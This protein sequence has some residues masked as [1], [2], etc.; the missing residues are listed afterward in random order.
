MELLSSVMLPGKKNFKKIC[1]VF[2]TLAFCSTSVSEL[3]AIR[4]VSGKMGRVPGVGSPAGLRQPVIRLT[5]F[6]S[7]LAAPSLALPSTLLPGVP[8]ATREAI[9]VSP[10]HQALPSI[11]R[12]VLT[13]SAVSPAKRAPV[14]SV[15]RVLGH[16]TEHVGRS[17]ESGNYQKAGASLGT[18]FEA[19][20][21]LP[22]STLTSPPV[23]VLNAADDSFG[24]GLKRSHN[25][26]S[27]ANVIVLTQLQLPGMSI[28]A[29]ITAP[30]TPAIGDILNRALTG[31]NDG[32]VIITSELGISGKAKTGTL[33]TVRMIDDENVLIESVVRVKIGK[34]KKEFS[35]DVHNAAV[36][37]VMEDVPSPYADDQSKQEAYE[38]LIEEIVAGLKIITIT[39]AAARKAVMAI[40]DADPKEAI[41]S[42]FKNVSLP[43]QHKTLEK[44]SK[45]QQLEVLAEA[46]KRT[47]KQLA[48]A[49]K[50]R[51]ETN[52]GDGK[53][54]QSKDPA[55]EMVELIKK[56]GLP[57]LVEKK[58]VEEVEGVINNPTPETQKVLQWAKF[59]LSLPWNQRTE[60]NLD[61]VRAREILDRD[62]FGLDQ[63]KDRIL[64][65][66][67]VRKRLKNKR[68]A[69]L[70]FTGPPGTG[71]TSIAK[72]IAEAMGREYIRISLGGVS[73]ESQLRGH[74]RTFQGSKAGVILEHLRRVNS[75]NPIMVLD[76][77]EKMSGAGSANGDPMAALLEILDPEQ[78]NAFTDHYLDLPFDLSEIIFI[79]TANDLSRIPG[80][81][82]DRLEIIEYHSCTDAEK[83]QI[84]TRYL[85]ARGRGETGLTEDEAV[86]K[87]S[88]LMHLIRSYTSEAGVRNLTRAIEGLFRK[89]VS[90]IETGIPT[91][92][93]ELTPTSIDTLIGPPKV[94]GDGK[95]HNGVGV[96]SALAVSGGGGSVLPIEVH[97]F[98][99]GSGKVEITGNLKETM[100]QSVHVAKTVVRQRGKSLGI[101]DALFKNMDMHIHV[102]QG[103]TP[104]DGPSAG[105]TLVTAI[106][107]R[108]TGRAVKAG[109]AMTGEVYSS[110]E[111]HAIGGLKE[112]VLGAM[113]LGYTTVIYPKENE[114]DV[115]TFSEEVRAGIELIA[116]ETIE[117]VLDLA[118][119]DAA[120]EAP[121]EV[122]K[123]EP[124]VVGAPVND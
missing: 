119:E 108:M 123:A 38:N 36:V 16:T 101:D 32:Y 63:V 110:G 77:L 74:G 59:L 25:Y 41:Y 112:K 53:Q 66:L 105:I 84:G 72:G 1:S 106:A 92:G 60:D 54:Q 9:T 96:A 117:E 12:K 93:L 64:E 7:M 85:D 118:L 104:K 33:A 43:W 70:L 42:V 111:V 11:G 48:E 90:N 56:A 69:I 27:R 40:R 86:L 115:A 107:S 102:P 121:L 79:A 76:E 24:S 113:K 15:L 73:T 52:S 116:V 75:K 82:R 95:V 55:V 39:N 122:A 114:M 58:A 34:V 83:I 94:H 97:A 13:R 30:P 88:G 71:K 28:Q 37:R 19:S 18:F 57:E 78:N 8:L 45:I 21:Q 46:T 44:N 49:G 61:L 26:P 124:A 51:S 35:N 67:A 47:V 14:G 31:V 99:N 68:G 50:K 87:E 80:P 2:I 22:G 81:L 91:Q 23:A 120:A 89:I 20:R 6:S 103:G 10:Q 100:E 3:W 17:I 109:V 29:N 4:A 98:P 5:D 62:H 65:F